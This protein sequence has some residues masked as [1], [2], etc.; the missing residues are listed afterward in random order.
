MLAGRAGMFVCRPSA[1]LWFPVVLMD[2]WSVFGLRSMGS[3]FSSRDYKDVL[4]KPFRRKVGFY[5]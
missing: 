4:L 2:G 3:M 1:C 5:A